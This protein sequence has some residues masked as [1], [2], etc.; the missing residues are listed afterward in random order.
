MSSPFVTRDHAMAA[1]ENAGPISAEKASWGSRLGSRNAMTYGLQMPTD[2]H[3]SDSEGCI[4]SLHFMMIQHELSKN[5]GRYRPGVI[6]V[7]D[8][9]KQQRV[10]EGPDADLVP[11]LMG[12]L[13]ESLNASSDVPAIVRAAMGHL[14]LVMIHPFSD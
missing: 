6:F 9:R 10:Y 2:P 11:R 7:Q 8:E 14:N 13:T 4:R 5:P 12:E 3:L 1:G